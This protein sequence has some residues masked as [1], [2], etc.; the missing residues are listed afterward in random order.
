MGLFAQNTSKADV[1][2]KEKVCTK[3]CDKMKKAPMRQTD[4]RKNER[5]NW[6]RSCSRSAQNRT[7]RKS[8]WTQAW[9]DGSIVRKKGEARCENVIEERF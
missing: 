4:V 9:N 2:Q 6:K 3:K 5:Q 7:Q 1:P 8:R